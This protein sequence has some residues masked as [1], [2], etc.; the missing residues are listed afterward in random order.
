MNYTFDDIFW[1]NK[2]PL[3]VWCTP[4]ILKEEKDAKPNP[5]P[6]DPTQN[7]KGTICN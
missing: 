3:C 4:T 5:R 6:I 1:L 2:K 7:E